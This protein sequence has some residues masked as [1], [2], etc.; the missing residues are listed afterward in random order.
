MQPSKLVLNLPTPEK[1]KAEFSCA[2]LYVYFSRACKV[3]FRR[4]LNKFGLIE[5]LWR[6]KCNDGSVL[7]APQ[8]CSDTLLSCHV[9]ESDAGTYYTSAVTTSGEVRCEIPVFPLDVNTTLQLYNWTVSVSS[10]NS[11]WSNGTQ[12]Y[13]YD[14][15][16]VTCNDTGNDTSCLPSQVNH[17]QYYTVGK[18][19]VLCHCLSVCFARCIVNAYSIWCDLSR[20]L[21][22]IR[23]HV[24]NVSCTV[25]EIGLDCAVFYVPA[26][27]G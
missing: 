3:L 5:H 24:E 17:W 22:I 27:T 6:A 12:V 23:D 9:Q 13:V 26:N 7:V 16:C 19:L 8:S 2:L 11:T 20:S 14:P 15:Q 25:Y 10:D 21:K 4:F 18:H 1:W